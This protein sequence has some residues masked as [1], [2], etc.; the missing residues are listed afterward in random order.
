VPLF[1]GTPT[2]VFGVIRAC[3]AY[4][5]GLQRVVLSLEESRDLAPIVREGGPGGH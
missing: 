2:A 4:E 3:V 1:F 5:P